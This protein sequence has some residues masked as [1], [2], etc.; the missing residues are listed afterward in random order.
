MTD[1]DPDTKPPVAVGYQRTEVADL[2]SAR[3]RRGM[4]D[5]AD[6]Y[7][8]LYAR[9]VN[10]VGAEQPVAVLLA[11]IGEL[12]AESVF[13]PS[14]EVFEAGAIPQELFEA[15]VDVNVVEPERTYSRRFSVGEC[16]FGWSR[17][18]E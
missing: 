9:T 5:L 14:L 12:E 3:E 17:G 6:R 4:R 16:D 1:P 11:I 13:V 8:Y 10:P 15:V 7:G 18:G 2:R